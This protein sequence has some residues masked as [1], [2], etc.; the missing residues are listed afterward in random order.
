MELFV[1]DCAPVEVGHE[2]T[3]AE[4]ELLLVVP[5]IRVTLLVQTSILTL[6]SLE[7]LDKGLSVLQAQRATVR[8]LR[9]VSEDRVVDVSLG[10]EVLKHAQAKVRLGDRLILL[11]GEEEEAD[12]DSLG[13]GSHESQK[14]V[15]N[16]EIPVCHI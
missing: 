9:I 14:R 13:Y 15:T 2:V 5:G 6:L 16:E 1:L 12:V 8:L 4:D 7:P 11:A 3:V 10:V